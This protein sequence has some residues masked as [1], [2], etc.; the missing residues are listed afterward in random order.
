[1]R[2]RQLGRGQRVVVAAET[3]RKDG[4]AQ[5]L[6]TKPSASPRAND[7]VD[8]SGFTVGSIFLAVEL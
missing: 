3:I 5:R 8:Q 6:T 2:G 1:M 7:T 4:L